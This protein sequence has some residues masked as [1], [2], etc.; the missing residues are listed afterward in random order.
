M[1]KIKICGLTNTE[2]ARRAEEL[3][4]DYLGFVFFQKSPRTIS[5]ETV[6]KIKE[7]LRGKAET[8][9]LFFNEKI[10]R[11]KEIARNCRLDVLQLHGDEE[12]QYVSE[13]KREFKVIKTFRVKKG[14]D[15]S[16]MDQYGMADFFLFDTLKKGMA[17]G[18]GVS[19]DWDMLA[20]RSFAKPIFLAGGLKPSNVKEAIEKVRP[21]SVDVSSGVEES[22][23]KKDF[24]KMETF[25]NA[26]R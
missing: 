6:S 8:V 19:F 2:D 26:A 18:T 10:L 1:A 14:F 16:V 12:P 25:I 7:A 21:F 20:G 22:P 4:A 3:G 24:N 9:G 15:F 17:G 13:L 23:E 5:Q 11:V